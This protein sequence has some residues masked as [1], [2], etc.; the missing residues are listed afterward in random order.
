MTPRRGVSGTGTRFKNIWYRDNRQGVSE[1]RILS[2]HRRPL[3]VF[4]KFLNWKD[5][6]SKTSLSYLKY[7]WM[8]SDFHGVRFYEY[9]EDDVTP[10]PPTVQGPGRNRRRRSQVDTICSKVVN[11]VTTLELVEGVGVPVPSRSSSRR[12]RHVRPVK[13][14]TN[15]IRRLSHH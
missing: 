5:S 2:K 3:K 7:V 14:D 8:N 11:T 9:P 6:S 15:L 13:G 12:R 10:R 4:T 1:R